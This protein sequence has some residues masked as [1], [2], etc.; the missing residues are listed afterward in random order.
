M[1]YLFLPLAILAICFISA[2][3]KGEDAAPTGKSED[4]A[5]VGKVRVNILNKIGQDS[6]Q[7]GAIRYVNAVGNRFSVSM[8][9]Y[10]IS[11]FSFVKADGTVINMGNHKLIDAS[12]PTNATFTLDS[13]PNGEYTSVRFLLGVDS[14][15]NHSG[16]QEGDLDPVKGMIWTWN[17]GYI[18]FKHEGNYID[19][20]GDTKTI[21]FHLGT[22]EALTPIAIPLS[23]NVRGN[24]KTITIAFNLA[25]AYTSPA[26]INFN[27]DNNHMSTARSDIPWIGAMSSNLSNAFYYVPEL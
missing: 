24:S 15:H 9:K 8:L 20:N 10:Y 21:V 12:D 17:T 26:D 4:T 14:A 19:A 1:K 27:V 5:S 23:L 25:S 6:I 13:L 16:A 7:F 2:C 3:K 11:N 22:D 18:F